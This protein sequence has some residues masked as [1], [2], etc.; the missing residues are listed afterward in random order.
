[1]T[2]EEYR[3][4]AKE[5]WA[6]FGDDL[7]IDDTARVSK[8]DEEPGAFVEAWVWVEDDGDEDE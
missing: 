8:A 5:V 1:M 2:D 3:K 4:K 6:R 7:E